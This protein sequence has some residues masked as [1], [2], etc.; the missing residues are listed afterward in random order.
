MKP[1]LGHG[2]GSVLLPVADFQ[3]IFRSGFTSMIF[4]NN[5]LWIWVKAGLVAFVPFVILSFTGLLISYGLF[6]KTERPH[7]KAVVLGVFLSIV[8]FAIAGFISPTMADLKINVW[9]GFIL[10]VVSLIKR[11]EIDATYNSNSLG[12][13]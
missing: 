9:L 3:Y 6:I 1:L 2:F 5:Y 10:G 7:H 13:A 12:S 11:F 4:H 8:N